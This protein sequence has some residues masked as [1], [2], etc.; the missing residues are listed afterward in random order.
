[1]NSRDDLARLVAQTDSRKVTRD[2]ALRPI[3][4]RTRGSPWI[5]IRSA[6]FLGSVAAEHR[7]EFDRSVDGPVRQQ[8]LQFPG[9]RNLEILRP[10]D[11]DAHA[12]PIYQIF[13]LVFADEAAMRSALESPVRQRVHDAMA[14]ILPLF[15]GNIVHYVRLITGE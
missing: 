2:R 14:P 8:L 15:D 7:E 10:I 5:I 4:R 13:N 9:L 11:K 6:Q 3:V 12:P 1:V